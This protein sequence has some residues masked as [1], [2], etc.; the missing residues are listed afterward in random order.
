[1]IYAFKAGTSVIDEATMNSILSLQPFSLIYDGVQVDAKTGAGV[2]QFDCA[3]YDHLISF[4][5]SG[6]TE[7][8]R[9]ELELVKDGIGADVIVEIRSGLSLDGST[10]GTLIKKM[11]LPTEFL[12][13]AKSYISIPVDIT[14]L[15]SGARYGLVIRKNG[16]ATNHFHVHGET[17]ADSNHL[18][19][20]RSGTG[21]WAPTNAI[22][23][24]IFSGENG[25][26]R[27]GM[28]GSGYTT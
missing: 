15:T 7:I 9:I 4:T 6:V 28:Y 19:Y 20:S 3:S 22:H 21:I 27:H 14:G 2:A 17:N 12:P 11:V 1:M 26:L 16:D 18:C 8:S 24:K 13:A 25:E 5:A 10:E 23:F